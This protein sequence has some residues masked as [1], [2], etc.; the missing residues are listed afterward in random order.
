VNPIEK[1]I[2]LLEDATSEDL[3]RL[4]G[5][6]RLMLYQQLRRWDRMLEQMRPDPEEPEGVLRRLAAGER[7]A[8]T[9]GIVMA[10]LT[11]R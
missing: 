3:A 9:P 10:I 6:E 11:V 5:A 4:C 8:T 2:A 7:A 1:A